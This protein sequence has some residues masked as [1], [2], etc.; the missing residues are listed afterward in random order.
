MKLFQTRQIKE[1]DRYTIQQEPI[2]SVDL[3]ERASE[4]FT[5]AIRPIIQ[6]SDKIFVFAGPGN[7]GGDALAASR[8]LMQSGYNVE[9][10]LF[11]TKGN[12]SSDCEENKKRLIQLGKDNFLE[13]KDTFVLPQMN[14]N[15]VIIDGLFGSGLDRP[16]S[17]GFASLVK[18]INQSPARV[19]SID[20]PS[21]LFGEDNSGNASDAII[22]AG[23]T[24]TFQFPKIAFFFPENEKYIGKWEALDIGLNPEIM[25]QIPSSFH[26]TEKI[27]V[28][29][30]LK[31]RSHFA[32]KGIFGHALLIA[33]SLGKMGAA[34]LSAKACL[35]SGI[36]LLTVHVPGSGNTILQTSVSEAMTEIDSNSSYFSEAPVLNT[37]DAVAI[38]PGLGLNIESVDAFMDLLTRIKAPLILDA[39]A[40]NMLDAPH[41]L[42][43][44]PENS[45]LTP[46]IG[47]F[48]RLAG[49]SPIVSSYQRLEAAISFACEKRVYLI[50]KGAFTAICT[51]DGNCFFNPTGNPGMATAG[52]GDVLTGILLSLAAQGYTMKEASILGVYLH[53]LA[54]DIATAKLSQE[55]MI[56]GDIIQNLGLA[57]R[58][59]RS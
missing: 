53:G 54:G 30:L 39:D 50:L 56:A 14:E 49:I 57:F 1:I 32:H 18:S 31:I 16:L 9:V 35:K 47:E 37:Y 48:N 38:G 28:K 55:S 8:M 24:F 20:M 2:A 40:L 3:M 15:D 45:I 43:M 29:R 46:H 34:V 25:E 21:G 4:V 12:L 36:G 58:E 17:G 59:I 5:E 19:V 6:M 7:N 23:N 13:I 27:D 10:Y 11:N 52:S 22:K 42:E 33:G 26:Y 41:K 51:P 44:I